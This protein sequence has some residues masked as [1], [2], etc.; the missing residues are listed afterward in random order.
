MS[1]SSVTCVYTINASGQLTPAQIVLIMGALAVPIP[2]EFLALTG[3]A[4]TSDLSVAGATSAARTVVFDITSAQFQ[5]QFPDDPLG[6]FWGLLTLP[7]GVYVN[8]QVI[9]SAPVAA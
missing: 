7:I 2:A 3:A 1:F 8:A 5:D 4:V 9:E 6:P